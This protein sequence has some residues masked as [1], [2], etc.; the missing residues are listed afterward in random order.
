MQ[1]ESSYRRERRRERER[2]RNAKTE[3]TMM[4]KFENS[5]HEIKMKTLIYIYSSRIC[6]ANFSFSL[7]EWDSPIIGLV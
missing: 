1:S 4:K 2:E 3:A 6:L 5:I 7:T